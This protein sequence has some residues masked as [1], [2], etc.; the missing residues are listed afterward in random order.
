MAKHI[1]IRHLQWNIAFVLL[2]SLTKEQHELDI[3]SLNPW[4]YLFYNDKFHLCYGWFWLRIS[5]NCIFYRKKSYNTLSVLEDSFRV[6]VELASKT[7]QSWFLLHNAQNTS[8]AMVNY[9][10]VV[11]DSD[12]TTAQFGFLIAKHVKIRHL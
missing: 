9:L 7:S 8:F 6:V 12:S 4:K 2:L 3:P 5:S 1:I 10:C 11:V